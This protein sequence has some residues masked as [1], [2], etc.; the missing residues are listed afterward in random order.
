MNSIIKLLAMLSLQKIHSSYL[1]GIAKN[2]LAYPF[3]QGFFSK[4]FSLVRSI[5]KAIL[6]I[7]FIFWGKQKPGH[8]FLAKTSLPKGH[9]PYKQSSDQ[10]EAE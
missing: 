3:G 8:G 1:S 2:C 9:D 6:S 5:K 7:F 4:Q 10:V